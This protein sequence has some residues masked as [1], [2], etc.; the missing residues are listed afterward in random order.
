M[1]ND[2]S[3]PNSPVLQMPLFDDDRIPLRA[4]E[5]FGFEL[6]YIMGHDGKMYF[7]LHSWL[8]GCVGDGAG[9]LIRNLRQKAVTFEKSQG[10]FVVHSEM[11][12]SGYHQDFEYVTDELLY[13]ITEDLRVT[14]DRP[15]VGAIKDYLAKAG[16]IVDKL[17]RDEKKIEPPRNRRE[18]V[19]VARKM[20]YEG[21]DKEQ[22]LVSLQIRRDT[23]VSYRE[24]MATVFKFVESPDFGRIANEEYIGLFGYDNKQLQSLLNTKSVRDSL[25][26]TQLS[27]LQFLERAMRDKLVAMGKSTNHQAVQELRKIAVSIRKVLDDLKI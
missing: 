2:N 15:V 5:S 11:S 12:G 16:A 1:S 9:K 26:D 7:R 13:R 4:A 19:F 6:P 21:K 22:S 3:N 25:T 17:R 18:K 14:K 8:T 27:G 10:Q 24:M 20:V 23:S